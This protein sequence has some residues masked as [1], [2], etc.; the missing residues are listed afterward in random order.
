MKPLLVLF[1]K[2]SAAAEKYH[3]QGKPSEY[4]RPIDNHA[5]DAEYWRSLSAWM[6]KFYAN[7][8]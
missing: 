3:E 6:M 1:H 5:Q 7:V 2:I 8:R 4:I